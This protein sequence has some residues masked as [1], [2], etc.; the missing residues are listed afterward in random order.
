MQS[1]KGNP[2]FGMLNEPNNLC[3]ITKWQKPRTNLCLPH[4]YSGPGPMLRIKIHNHICPQAVWGKTGREQIIAISVLNSVMDR[5]KKLWE[6]RRRQLTQPAVSKEDFLRKRILKLKLNCQ[7][8][9]NK[10][11]KG[12]RTEGTVNMKASRDERE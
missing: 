7:V 12:G 2:G 4:P 11:N 8:R 5:H 3:K 9:L 1:S 10:I 6:Y